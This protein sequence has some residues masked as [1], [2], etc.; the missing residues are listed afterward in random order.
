[1]KEI[2]NSDGSRNWEANILLDNVKRLEQENAELKN[3]L[4]CK[5]GT[6]ETLKAEN[7]QLKEEVRT[8]KIYSSQIEELEESLNH[9][10]QKNAELK[11]ELNQYKKYKF[12]FEKAKEFKEKS[13]K[14]AEKCLAEN[15]DLKDTIK[16]TVCQ[17]ECFRYKQATKYKQTLQEIKEIID[18]RFK[19]SYMTF[20]YKEY[21]KL[22]EDIDK[23]VNEVIGA[24]E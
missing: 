12:L 1:M 6:I 5:N 8:E 21:D 18:F 10:K 14:W 16:R 7:E 9:L 3:I 23:I 15:E 11:A 22:I 13:D 17:A 4:D 2:I 24:E 19:T 20:G